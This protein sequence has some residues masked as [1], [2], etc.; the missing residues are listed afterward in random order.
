V[1]RAQ[2]LIILTEKQVSPIQLSYW[3]ASQNNTTFKV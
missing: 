3:S 2:V 1:V